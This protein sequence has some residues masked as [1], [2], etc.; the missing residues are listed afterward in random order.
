MEKAARLAK[1]SNMA[2]SI[3]NDPNSSQSDKDQARRIMIGVQSSMNKLSS[4]WRS[5][6]DRQRGGYG[7]GNNI[8]K[9]NPG[10]S[11]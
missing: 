4:E 6:L 10:L 8:T 7:F 9:I 2:Q 1:M 11:I 3:L 5:D